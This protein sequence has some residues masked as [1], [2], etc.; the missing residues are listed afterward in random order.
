M[1]PPGICVFTDSAVAEADR[2]TVSAVQLHARDSLRLVEVASKGIDIVVYKSETDENGNFISDEGEFRYNEDAIYL[3]LYSGLKS[4]KDIDSLSQ[5]TILRTFAHEFTH[6]NE[7]WSPK[8]YEKLRETVLEEMRQNVGED[9][10]EAMIQRKLAAYRAKVS[11]SFTYD[12]AVRE[13]VADALTDILPQSRFVEKLY[14]RDRGL[15]ENMRQSLKDFLSGIREYF[16][17]LTPNNRS[18]AVAAKTMADG[19]TRYVQSIVRVF[20][21]MAVKGAENYRSAEKGSAE[22]EDGKK[23]QKA[24]RNNSLTET[25][26]T[27]VEKFGTTENFAE[28]GYILPNGKM[29]RFTRDEKAGE[30]D[31]DHRAIALAYGEDVDLNNRHGFYADGRYLERFVDDGNIRI[32]VGDPD[33]DIDAGIQLSATVPPT[34]EQEQTIREFIR[35]KKERD[36][37]FVGDENSLY[38]GF[39]PL[40]I[41]FG[42]DAGLAAGYSPDASSRRYIGDFS[43][44]KIINDIRTYY[45]TGEAPQQSIVSQFHSQYRIRD[46]AEAEIRKAVSDKNYNGEI[47]L[48]DSSPSIMLG[49]RGVRNLPMLMKASH[50]RENILTAYE[51]KKLGITVNDPSDFHG[52][53]VDL[54]LKVIDSL[55]DTALAYRG[56]K[57]ADDPARREKCFLLLPRIKNKAGEDILVPVYINEKGNYNN[58]IIDTN[59]I[60]SVYGKREIKSYIQRELDKKNIVRIKKRGPISSE[61]PAPIAVNYADITS[62]DEAADQTAMASYAQSIPRTAADSQEENKENQRQL[63]ES[64]LSDME[65]L[66]QTGDNLK[67]AR[68]TE[69]EKNALSVYRKRLDELKKLQSRQDSERARL[70]ESKS[71]SEKSRLQG[72]ID[73]CLLSGK[74]IVEF[75]LEF[76]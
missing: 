1:L 36:D 67:A 14:R 38:R 33:L 63:R 66:E 37:S 31:F 56:T 6:F 20:D 10:L 9:E 25:G 26:K 27:A 23:S 58:V 51:A 13:V 50:I 32:E 57:N 65:V 71:Q 70:A 30:R 62:P 52:L 76:F 53:G 5:Y 28:A 2:Y 24:I 7:K 40:G 15:A 4:I 75:A 35:W 45:R 19:Q 59:K 8:L 16:S 3:D 68:L 21:E 49:Q 22:R 48:T 46:G 69:A 47:R 74:I 44:D 18:E 64:T 55:D 43:A 17:K 42:G 41:D 60:A 61:S 11:K 34:R 39:L 29:L 54:Y 73:I 12:E 72:S